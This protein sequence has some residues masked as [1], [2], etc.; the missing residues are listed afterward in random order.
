M[1]DRQSLGTIC[2]IICNPGFELEGPELKKCTNNRG[3]WDS[4]FESSF[5]KDVTPPVITCPPNITANTKPG[6]KFGN[7]AWTTPDVADNS[8]SDL[9]VW[10]KPSIKKITGFK[11]Q[12]GNTKVTYF[13]QDGHHNKANCSFLVTIRGWKKLPAELQSA[14]QFKIRF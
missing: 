2:K 3:L 11:F 10:M 6:K 12:I 8:G 14:I 5:C 13:A 7:V 1:L 4:K 9:S